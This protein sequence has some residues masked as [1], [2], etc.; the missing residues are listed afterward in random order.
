M[1]CSISIFLEILQSVLE[2][3]AMSCRRSLPGTLRWDAQG[4]SPGTGVGR[5]F[6]L[7]FCLIHCIHLLGRDWKVGRE[8]QTVLP[9]GRKM[10][11]LGRSTSQ[12]GPRV[13]WSD[14]QRGGVGAT[15]RRESWHSWVE[16]FLLVQPLAGSEPHV[17]FCSPDALFYTHRV[18]DWVNILLGKYVT[19]ENWTHMW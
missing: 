19:Y 4:C 10:R 2:R 5:D 11:H 13:H 15:P 18:K 7:P 1:L 16:G 17:S 3:S 12:V 6:C 14:G 8:G 9:M